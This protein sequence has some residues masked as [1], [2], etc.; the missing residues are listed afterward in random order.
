VTGDG[1]T[2]RLEQIAPDVLHVS[3]PRRRGF[4]NVQLLRGEKGWT[5]V[6]SGE[7]SDVARD[8]LLDLLGSRRVL[9][10]GISQIFLTHGHG[11][12]T[13]LA[14]EL[15]MLTGATVL[16][17]ES[18]LLGDPVDLE[19]LRRHGFE[20]EVTA[21][22]P[23][24]SVEGIPS[25]QFRRAS[26]GDVLVTGARRFRL[27]ATPGHHRGHLCAFDPESGLLLSGD[28]V[29]RIPTG[30][31]LLTDLDE[32]PLGEHLDSHDVLRAL[33][34]RRVLPGH[35]RSFVDIRAALDEDR[36][37]HEQE[38]RTVLAA[39]PPTGASAETIAR[40]AFLGDQTADGI[41]PLSAL[42]RSLAVLRLLERKDL[43]R[44]DPTVSPIRFVPR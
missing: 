24:S 44:A 43:V 5:L 30:V 9:A 18:T 8:A 33:A 19:F 2:W 12:H 14:A 3:I 10:D 17:H 38:I 22:R 27:I 32:D 20:T 26:A 36:Q 4:V 35:G 11:D 40:R 34:V 42:G 13:G 16:A 25:G 37:A 31:R 21:Q 41:V 29:L 7:Q 39:L 6:D 1:P 23:S 28:R 15:A